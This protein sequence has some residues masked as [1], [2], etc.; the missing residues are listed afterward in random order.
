MFR[1]ENCIHLQWVPGLK[2]K[3]HNT[4]ILDE[5]PGYRFDMQV[6]L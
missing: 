2:H 5:I 4:F 6:N 3:T 1:F